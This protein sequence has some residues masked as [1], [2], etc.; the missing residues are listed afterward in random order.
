MFFGRV[1]DPDSHPRFESVQMYQVTRSGTAF[2]NG[3]R[4]AVLMSWSVLYCC[5]THAQGIVVDHRGT[6]L[7]KIPAAWIEAVR[8][9]KLNV[10]YMYRSHGSQLTYGLQSI[11]ATN[12]NYSFELGDR[13]LPTA[14]RAV[15]IFGW[16]GAVDGSALQD[17]FW[18]GPGGQAHTGQIL[19]NNPTIT[20]ATWASSSEARDWRSQ[21]T[22]NY[23]ESMALL[24]ARYTNVILDRKSTRLNSSHLGISYA[25]F[26]L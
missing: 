13:V 18:D 3:C 15:N 1:Q 21:D 20:V 17:S 16:D 8:N 24:E 10:Y 14:P 26:C 23:L 5:E 6:D 11:Q 4:L 25:V 22:T 19:S 2:V 12:G 7:S 9:M